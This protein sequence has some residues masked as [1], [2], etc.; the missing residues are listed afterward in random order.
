MKT[1]NLI[2][3][4]IAIVCLIGLGIGALVREHSTIG[5]VFFFCALIAIL[6][7]ADMIKPEK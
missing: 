7:L 2:G 6:M 1:L 3:T 5:F 4:L